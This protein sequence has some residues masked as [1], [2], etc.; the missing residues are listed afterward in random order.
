M[1]FLHRAAGVATPP[2]HDARRMLDLGPVAAR[3]TSPSR[4]AGGPENRAARTGSA[5]EPSQPDVV[6]RMFCAA[7][8]VKKPRRPFR[9]PGVEVETSETP[10]FRAA[11]PSFGV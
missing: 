5:R 8:P 6:N 4:A 2:R 10:V 7:W 1:H 9:N 3:R 11:G